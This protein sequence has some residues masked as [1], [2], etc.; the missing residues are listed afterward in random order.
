MKRGATSK[1]WKR[2]PGRD[3]SATRTT[4][5]DREREKAVF[6][7]IIYNYSNRATTRNADEPPKKAPGVLF[8][9]KSPERSALACIL[10]PVR[11]RSKKKLRWFLWEGLNVCGEVCAVGE[12]VEGPVGWQRIP[13]NC[14]TGNIDKECEGVV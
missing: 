3:K 10:F 11:S 4:G 9:S 14:E 5:K 1:I 12:E 6:V 13:K 2:K 8:K 7:F